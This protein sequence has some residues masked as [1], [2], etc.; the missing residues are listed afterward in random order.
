MS[1]KE[2]AKAKKAENKNVEQTPQLDP[3]SFNYRPDGTVEMPAQT[4]GIL[5]AYFAE[6]AQRNMPKKYFLHQEPVVAKKKVDGKMKTLVEWVDFKD[7]ESYKNQKPIE[8]RDT[9]SFNIVYINNLLH[10]AHIE[11]I[12]NGNAVPVATLEEEFKQSQES[13][14]KKVEE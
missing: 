11:N 4:F 5:R 8:M 2:E 10:G 13:R 12:N 3:A 1:K 6:Q 9:D 14:M 7:D